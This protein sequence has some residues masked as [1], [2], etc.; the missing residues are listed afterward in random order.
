MVSSDDDEEAE[1]I[2]DDKY[3]E[4]HVGKKE[5]ESNS[6]SK[7]KAVEITKEELR[8][9]CNKIMDE[10]YTAFSA[11]DIQTTLLKRYSWNFR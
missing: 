2:F 10:E 5:M 7:R 8:D 1:M 6:S 4:D 11:D 3:N 9:H